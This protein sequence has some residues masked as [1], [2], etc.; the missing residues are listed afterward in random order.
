MY[1]SLVIFIIVVSLVLTCLTIYNHTI[2][3]NYQL[4][5]DIEFKYINRN[6]DDGKVCGFECLIKKALLP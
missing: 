5:K 3:K 4:E 6:S 2:R 1:E